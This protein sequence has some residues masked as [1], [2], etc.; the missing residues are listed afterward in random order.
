MQKSYISLEF[1]P[2]SLAFADEDRAPE[3]ASDRDYFYYEHDDHLGSSALMT[4]GK[5]TA[6]HSG[7][8]YRRGD[9]LQRFEY[10]PFG[11]ETYSLNPNL[12][13]DPSYTGQK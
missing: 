8:M 11:K 13:I 4:E 7:L 9:L 12:Q 10:A 6:R 2:I 5:E 1:Q 3:I